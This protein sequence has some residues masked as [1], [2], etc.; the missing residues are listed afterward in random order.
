MRATLRPHP[1]A[2]QR[3][4]PMRGAM[5]NWEDP[6][7]RGLVFYVPLIEM[8]AGTGGVN[9]GKAGFYDYVS[10]TVGRSLDATSITLDTRDLGTSLLF[11]GATSDIVWGARTDTP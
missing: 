5:I 1:L 8:W 6:L 11:S 3:F 7:A 10:K 4:K 2:S 9:T